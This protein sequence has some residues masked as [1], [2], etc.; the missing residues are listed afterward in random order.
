MDWRIVRLR[1]Y[2]LETATE[3]LI[4]EIKAQRE[5]EAVQAKSRRNWIGYASG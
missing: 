4:V 5:T 3:K 1:V 2:W